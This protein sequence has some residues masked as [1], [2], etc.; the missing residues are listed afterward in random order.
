MLEMRR[1]SNKSNYPMTVRLLRKTARAEIV[2]IAFAGGLVGERREGCLRGF[3]NVGAG[4]RRLPAC[5]FEGAEN[6]LDAPH[7]R[8]FGSL[9]F[10]L[11]S[12][13]SSSF[14]SYSSE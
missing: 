1:A 7:G 14:S 9:L 6:Q 11:S 8:F 2:A 5:D 12:F 13:F 10:V 4:E 3:P